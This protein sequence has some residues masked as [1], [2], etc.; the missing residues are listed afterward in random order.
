M[1]YANETM[2][3][4]YMVTDVNEILEQDRYMLLGDYMFSY[5]DDDV[6]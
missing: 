3:Y 5:M 6:C 1:E 2:W 4:S